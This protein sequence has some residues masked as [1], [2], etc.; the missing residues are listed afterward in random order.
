MSRTSKQ[1]PSTVK[2]AEYLREYTYWPEDVHVDYPE[3]EPEHVLAAITFVLG[4]EEDRR[5][6]LTAAVETF[7]VVYSESTPI[8]IVRQSA[9]SALSACRAT[10]R[11]PV[12]FPRE[13]AR[14]ITALE[15][16]RLLYD[17]LIKCQIASESRTRRGRRTNYP[18]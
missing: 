4:E 1:V 11:M 3:L 2:L 7:N 18:L 9:R 16:A 6:T 17:E 14:Y 5:A 13:V 10:S 15:E 8:G 12:S